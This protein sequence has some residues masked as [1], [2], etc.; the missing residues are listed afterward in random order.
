MKITALETVHVEAYSNLVWVRLHTDEGLIGLGETFRNPQ[1]TIAYLHETCA[2]YLLGQDPLAIERHW[3]ALNH[4]VGNH[5]HGFPTRSVELRGN[6]AVDMALW[7]LCGKAAG[8][9]LY[10]LLGGLSRDKIRIYNT[11]AGYGYNARARTQ[12]DSQRIT[13]EQPPARHDPERPYEDLEAQ[14][15]RPAELA[16]SLLLEGITALK[17]WPFDNYALASD[18][19]TI[20]P[21]ALKAGL[22]AVEE[23]RKAVGD[24]IDIMLEFH[25]LWHLPAALEIARALADYAIFW[26]EDPI[27]MQN[28]DDL[29]LYKRSV[30]SRVCGSENLGTLPWYRETLT[31]QAIDVV[32][33]DMAWIGGL[34]EGRRIAAF[35]YAFDR[36]IAPHDCTGPVLLAANAH[37]LLSAP[38]ALIAETVR[39]YYRGFYRD[40]VTVLPRIDQGFLY[41][42]EGPGLG[43]DLQPELLARADAAIRRSA[44]T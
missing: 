38:N 37:L 7:D 24:R 35:A 30:V 25:G 26:L 15:H 16:Q 29:A 31:R 32:H 13:R 33:F 8:L 36:P 11:C 19:H 27:S 5:F 28:F 9:P 2:P 10:R 4:R 21:Q 22:W 17:I 12:I 14:V 3:H 41:P 6:S 23:I 1:A 20:S 43:T 34:T 44:L 40:I 39:A 18:G 42:L